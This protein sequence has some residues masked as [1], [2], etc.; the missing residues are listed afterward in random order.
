MGGLGL[1]GGQG[2]EGA[3]ERA[4][5]CVCIGATQP[6]QLLMAINTQAR[7]LGWHLSGDLQ[8]KLPTS[9]TGC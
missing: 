7:G 3:D 8:C 4:S 6:R 2:I 1:L 5:M 9:S